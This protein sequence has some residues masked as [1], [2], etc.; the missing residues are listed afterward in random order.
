MSSSESPVILITGCS[1]G[2]GR[3]LAQNALIRGLRVVATARR[4]S[5]ITDL[6]DKGAQIFTLD[7]TDSPQEIKSFA[8]KAINAFG[9]VDILVNN[10]GWLLGGAIEEITPEEVKS[11]FDTNFFGIINITNAFMPHLRARKTGTIVNVSSA[12]SYSALSGGGMYAASK[13]ALECLT[14]TWAHELGP[15]N[16]RAMSVNLGAFR[17]SVA[18]APNTKSPTNTINDYE[19]THYYYN[20]FREGSGKEI[21]DPDKGANKVLDVVMLKTDKALPVRFALGDDAV[22]LI[23]RRLK[24]RLAELDEW[25]SFGVGTNID[26]T[27]YEE[28]AWYE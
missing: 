25:E 26:G 15:F 28:V 7:V 6:G 22:G 13:A 3:S 10:A 2:F 16:I 24:R 1:T 18:S 14:E 11:Q 5:A 9:Q 4:L 19:L 8:E 21:G 17:T 27:K 23:K 12:G 20:L